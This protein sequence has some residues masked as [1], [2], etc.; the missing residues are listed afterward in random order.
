MSGK[1]EYIVNPKTGRKVNV[2]SKLGKQI[3]N[4]Y[5]T[6][7]GGAIRSLSIIPS[8]QFLQA[9]GA[10]SVCGGTGHNKRTCDKQAKKT[11]VKKNTRAKKPVVAKTPVK[12][13][14]R[15]KKPVAA[16]T[17]SK[18]KLDL[19]TPVRKVS[20]SKDV[21]PKAKITKTKKNGK[22]GRLSAGEY[23]RT[24]REKAIGDRCNIRQDGEYKCM[25]KRKNNT[26]Y[27]AK[28]SKTG[29]GQ[30]SCEDWS[31]KCEEADFQ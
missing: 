26:V 3:L 4:K 30:E 28:K 24:Y 20:A 29:A 17:R 19:N 7:L 21:K 16:K 5:I 13:N 10:C 1:F 25:L 6:Q 23:Y 31:S 18:K 12:K 22:G 15:A 27:W 11:P 9:G 14:T 8:N 2:S